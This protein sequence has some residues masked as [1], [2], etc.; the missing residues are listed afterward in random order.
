MLGIGSADSDS[1]SGASLMIAAG[2]PSS[3]SPIT[4][5]AAETRLSAT[6]LR[7]IFSS[8]P[9]R[10]LWPLASSTAS[11]PAQ[12][13]AT[14]T[15]PSRRGWVRLSPMITAMFRPFPSRSRIWR[16]E[17]RGWDG[18]STTLPGGALELS[19]PALG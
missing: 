14:P 3:P 18:N 13:K 2:M 19:M 9:N 17:A 11:R 1:R 15:Q 8:R 5:W 10:S 4:I 12:A 6:A 7:V 16:A